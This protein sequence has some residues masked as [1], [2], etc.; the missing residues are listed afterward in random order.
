MIAILDYFLHLNAE[1]NDDQS[2]KAV[3]KD[4]SKRDKPIFQFIFSISLFFCLATLIILT[5]LSFRAEENKVNG[6]YDDSN[7]T[8]LMISMCA[9]GFFLGGPLRSYYSYRSIKAMGSL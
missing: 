6:V 2:Q 9:L 3:I 7:V 1:K 4:E 5:K 8:L